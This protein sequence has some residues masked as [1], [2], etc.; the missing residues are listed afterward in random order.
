MT[1]V[2]VLLPFAIAVHFNNLIK[3]INKNAML[4]GFNM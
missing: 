3:M 2:M 4:N 1:I